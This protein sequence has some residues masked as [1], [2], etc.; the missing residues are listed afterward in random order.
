MYF[1]GIYISERALLTHTCMYVYKTLNTKM[2][3]RHKSC[4]VLFYLALFLLPRK[5]IW[6]LAIKCLM[7]TLQFSLLQMVF[8]TLQRCIGTFR[9]PPAS[10]P[11]VKQHLE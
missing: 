8:W 3:E 5:K 9:W 4:R 6:A 11:T 2:G 7:T 10:I 1:E